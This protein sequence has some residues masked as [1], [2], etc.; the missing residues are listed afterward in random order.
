MP[1]THMQAQTTVE[2]NTC[3]L[4]GCIKLPWSCTIVTVKV[5]SELMKNPEGFILWIQIVDFKWIYPKHLHNCFSH[6]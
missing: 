2:Q 3:A 1:Y 5:I 4:R 6:Y